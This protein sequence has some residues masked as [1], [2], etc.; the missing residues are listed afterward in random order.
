MAATTTATR[1]QAPSPRGNSNSLVGFTASTEHTPSCVGTGEDKDWE[2]SSFGFQ[3][4][5]SDSDS[6]LTPSIYRVKPRRGKGREDAT[7]AGTSTLSPGSVGKE[8][9][10]EAQA[11]RAGE[12]TA[13]EVSQPDSSFTQ[14][15]C[16]FCPGPK[17]IF[18]VKGKGKEI[19]GCADEPIPPPGSPSE[20]STFT[21]SD[22]DPR[23]LARSF[24]APSILPP[25][26]P[27][28]PTLATAP[29]SLNDTLSCVLALPN[30]F[31]P[32]A[33]CS[34][35]VCGWPSYAEFTSEG[36]GRVK[37]WG[38]EWDSDLAPS[39]HHHASADADDEE[40][41]ISLPGVGLG[42]FLPVPRFRDIV[43]PRLGP[44][45][46]DERLRG[47]FLTGVNGLGGVAGG[48]PWEMRLMAGERWDLHAERRIWEVWARGGGVRFEDEDEG[49]DL[50]EEGAVGVGMAKGLV[51]WEA[52]DDGKMIGEEW[53]EEEAE[54]DDEV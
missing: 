42:R 19:A 38:W 14:S 49:W 2:G 27:P 37:R 48:V 22:Y 46:T 3:P 23:K 31:N 16:P 6:S 17:L 29:L 43:D 50:L 34:E 12:D 13:D 30:P 21:P 26:P 40:A 32:S 5:G 8:D 25:P 20:A 11:G 52:D 18:E 36:D 7:E 1:W 44:G 39:D 51:G 33:G 24:T 41:A 54:D 15:D 47:Y 28:F 53:R 45:L 35:P 10:V 9:D 4:D